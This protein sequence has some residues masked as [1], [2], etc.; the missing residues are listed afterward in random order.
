MAECHE[1]GETR[2]RWAPRPDGLEESV[3][4]TPGY[5][6][7]V[8]GWHGHGV[9]GMEVIWLLRGPAGAVQLRAVTDW[10][11]GTLAPGHGYQPDGRY[12]GVN[13]DGTIRWPDG[14]G[15]GWHA[16]RP[17]YEGHG[18]ESE[19]CPLTGG[20]CYYDESLSG[21][22][23]AVRLFL[24]RGE[25]VIWNELEEAYRRLVTEEMNAKEAA[26]NL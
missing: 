14:G 13:D 10:I 16:K 12:I 5:N 19:H 21:A 8:G 25:Q 17:Q 24:Q 18:V 3:Q 22:D 4:F 1:R 20:I 26:A 11:P 7:P 15:I 23:S 6:C 2:T 9:H